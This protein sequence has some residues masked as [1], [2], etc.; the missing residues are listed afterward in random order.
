MK[1]DLTR[2]PR[3]SSRVNASSL[4]AAAAI[5]SGEAVPF[6]MEKRREEPD[7]AEDA[8]SFWLFW[9]V[10]CV[11]FVAFMP[12]LAMLR[13]SVI[14]VSPRGIHRTR[15]KVTRSERISL[16]FSFAL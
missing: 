7:F 11:V 9:T 13:F 12:R 14:V 1:A 2:L 8:A 16:S 10:S 3:G 6:V 4:R 15:Q 5:S